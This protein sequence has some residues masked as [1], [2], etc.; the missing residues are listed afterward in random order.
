[1]ASKPL[2]QPAPGAVRAKNPAMKKTR[3]CTGATLTVGTDMAV[4]NDFT[5]VVGVSATEVDLYLHW[6]SDLLILGKDDDNG[7]DDR[8]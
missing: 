6:A 1:M 7:D 5:V 2:G 4:F 8:S 3:L